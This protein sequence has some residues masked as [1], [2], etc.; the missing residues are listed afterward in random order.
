[1]H[2]VKRIFRLENSG[3]QKSGRLTTSQIIK[4]ISKSFKLWISNQNMTRIGRKRIYKG[5]EIWTRTI[6]EKENLRIRALKLP[7]KIIFEN[8]KT[9]ENFSCVIEGE[10]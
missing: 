6:K 9:L 7:R 3:S 8:Y 5:K 4:N 10:I 2:Y 1:M